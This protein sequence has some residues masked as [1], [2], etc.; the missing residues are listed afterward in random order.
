MT[1]YTNTDETPRTTA[2]LNMDFAWK[3]GASFGDSCVIMKSSNQYSLEPAACTEEANYVCIKSICPA[4]FIMYDK[5]FCAKVMDSTA[6]K[7]DAVSACRDLNPGANLF[8]PTTHYDQ[9][10]MKNFLLK[11]NENNEVYLGMTKDAN[12]HWVWDT[13]SPVFVSPLDWIT[14]PT[15][16]IGVNGN[17]PS[18]IVN[19]IVSDDLFMTHDG[20]ANKWLEIT[21][22]EVILIPAVKVH[23]TYTSNSYARYLDVRVGNES[24]DAAASSTNKNTRCEYKTNTPQDYENLVFNCPA[25]GLVGNK[26]T[27]QKAAGEEIRAVEVQMFGE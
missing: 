1:D 12:G 10:L 14:M 11:S 6:T 5:K 24:T 21:L 25:P 22:P 27:I 26:I 16:I 20:N 7:D 18:R 17:S 15:A 4:G 19:G 9:V 3:T 8:I 23:T 13:G 2:D